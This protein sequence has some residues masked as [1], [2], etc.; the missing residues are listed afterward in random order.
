[1]RRRGAALVCAGALAL[2]TACTSPAPE[3]TRTPAA[4]TAPPPVATASPAPT[5]SPTPAP[6]PLGTD[7]VNVLLI[8]SDSRTP[9]DLTGMADTIML[10]HV[11][12]DRQ[13]V[14]LVSFTR[15][16]WVDIPGLGQGKINSAF[17]RGGTQTLVDTVSG[18]L[19]GVEIDS[20][21]QTTF[22]GFI[23][24]TRALDG[25]EVDNKHAST[26]TVQSTGRVV[27]FPE[28]RVTLSGTDGLIY[29]RERKRLPLGDLDR[30]ERQRAALIGMMDKVAEVSHD[31]VRLAEVLRFVAGNVKITG[32]LGVLDLA[33]LVPLVRDLTREDV[34][35][36]MVPITGFG[37]VNGASVNV[38]DTTQ[39]AALGQA[40]RDDDLAGYV[41][42]YGT[43]YA[44]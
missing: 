18:L 6:D 22:D 32:D 42:T 30:T 21:V 8:G 24:L 10:V 20:T 31:P 15:D 28:G 38:V 39:T 36:L 35:G 12:A 9:G 19:G 17:S 40:L 29:V 34:V 7:P 3:P 11:P 23:A 5:P 14:Y 33:S 2:L 4:I 44:P 41:A 43:D 37:N 26:V 25:F 27:A 1:M 13:Q 16:M